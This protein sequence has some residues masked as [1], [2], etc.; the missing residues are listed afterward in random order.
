MTKK[1]LNVTGLSVDSIDAEGQINYVN[2]HTTTI[3]SRQTA[4]KQI[5]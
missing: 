3:Y 1:F 5:A 2:N 4:S